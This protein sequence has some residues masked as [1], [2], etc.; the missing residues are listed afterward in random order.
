MMED[1][2]TLNIAISG[3]DSG[4]GQ[5]MA[6][7]IGQNSPLPMDVARI[8]FQNLKSDLPSVALVCKNWMALADDEVFRKMIRP[9][10]AFGTQEWKEYIDVDAGE[11]P[12][13][14]RRAYADLEKE[15]GVL[16]F[17][18]EK[19]KVIENGKEVL[20]DNLEV[21]GKLVGNPKKGNKTG[22]THGSWQEAISEKRKQEKPHWVWIKKEVIGRNKTYEQQQELVAKEEN[23]KAP[24]ANISGLIDTAISVFMEYVRSEERYSFWGPPVND[25]LTFVRVDGQTDGILIRLGFGPFGLYVYGSDFGFAYEQFAVA[26]ARKYFGHFV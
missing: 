2:M 23:T 21:I 7:P 24:G 18:P 1:C 17:I 22:Y 25:R 8:I 3:R 20:L 26:P 12:H 9:A 15:D 11:E 13:L 16:T 19:V 5:H 14:P 6:D 4:N 10:Q